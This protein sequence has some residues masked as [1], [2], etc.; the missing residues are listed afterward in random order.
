VRPH[1]PAALYS[2]L[3]SLCDEQKNTWDVACGSGQAAV[4]LAKYF[5]EVHATDVSEQ[6][7]TNAIPNP[8]VRYS[9]QP[10]EK[11]N[12]AED[13]FDLVS[14]AQALHWFD[15][16]LFWQEVKR[17]LKPNG[18]FAAWG[19]AWFLDEK[20]NDVLQKDFFPAI[21]PYWAEQNQILWNGYRDVPFPFERV[22]T[23]EFEMK[24]DWDLAQLFSYLQTWSSVRQ[25]LQK[26]GDEEFLMRTYE[27]LK[28]LWG[29]GKEKKSIKMDFTL[30]VGRNNF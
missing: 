10:A 13:Q 30:L 16:D 23:P 18:F 22:E 3:A 29:D 11:T 9:V 6:Q 12:F 8:R 7:I 17:A 26:D 24:M 21:E 27:A 5:A 28:S 14:V 2:F 4:D 20:I 19:Y 25:Y 1:Y 15:Y